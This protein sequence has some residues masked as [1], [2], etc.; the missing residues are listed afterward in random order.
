MKRVSIIIP[1]YKTEKYLERCLESVVAQNYSDIEIIIINDCSPD[2]SERLILDFIN[3]SPNPD[4]FIYHKNEKNSGLSLSRNKGIEL[5]TGD[6]IYFLDSDDALLNNEVITELVNSINNSSA[7]I[8]I[9]ETQQVYNNTFFDNPYHDIKTEKNIL[10]KSDIIQSYLKG[11]WAAIACNR[12]YSKYFIVKNQLKF[13]KVR[14]FEDEIWSFQVY[15]LADKVSFLKKKTYLYYM[16]ENPNSITTLYK[17][18][19]QSWEVVL[20]EKLKCLKKHHFKLGQK[21]FSES[22]KQDIL[23]IFESREV[24]FSEW[25]IN[26]KRIKTILKEYEIKLL[27]PS[28]LAFLVYRNNWKKIE[29]RNIRF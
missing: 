16:G 12:L 14:A 17:T 9:A 4:Q 20:K 5:S 1:V 15:L 11:K 3:N 10:T 19:I 24:N 13:I 6:F 21:P 8:C 29:L 7:D 28:V 27:L 18:D 2:N 25:S 22:I 23:K 26:Y